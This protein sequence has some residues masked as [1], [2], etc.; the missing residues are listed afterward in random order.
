MRGSVCECIYKQFID[1]PVTTFSIVIDFL[2]SLII[3]AIGLTVNCR[4]RQKLK[5]E[6]RLVLPAGRKGNVIE[7]IMRWYLLLTM[8]YWPYE[9]TI[10][11]IM[12]NEIIPSNWLSNALFFNFYWCD[13]TF[14]SIKLG[15]IIVG[16][17]SFF[18][19]LIRYVYIV[20]PTKS[21]Q[22]D[23]KRAGRIFAVASLVFPIAVDTIENITRDLRIDWYGDY[24]LV[25]TMLTLTEKAPESFRECLALTGGLNNTSLVFI[26]PPVIGESV[27]RVLPQ[28]LLDT[29]H[30]IDLMV[31]VV[32]ASNIVE[33][34]FY[35]KMFQSAKRLVL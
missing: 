7:P 33:A 35:F 1:T 29:I 19:S 12:H 34:Y 4:F 20:H 24:G 2:F 23:F 16:Y 3:I 13:F 15:R 8:F 27:S 11:W 10:F 6:K 14:T 30:F 31:I 17:N 18:V 25:W 22:W 28:Q 26:P 21:N 5:E 9:M 32:I